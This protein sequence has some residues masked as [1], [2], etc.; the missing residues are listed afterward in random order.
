VSINKHLPHESAELHVSG[1]ADYTD[2]IPEVSGTLYCALGL[3]QRAHALITK[4]D[5]QHVLHAAGVVDVIT[6]TDIPGR[7]DCG[8]IQA[9]LL[10][11]IEYED[12][13]PVLTP[14]E[15]LQQ[16]SFVVPPIHRV[17]GNP[18][19]KLAEAPHRIDGELSIGGQE[20]F[21]LEG[22]ISYAIPKEQS[23]LCCCNRRSSIE[24]TDQTPIGS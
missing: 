14:K 7:N 5:L 24:S 18:D 15:A 17:Q 3:S 10:A 19:V 9:A 4:M 6:A 1:E 2:D 22:Q 8:P 13:A 16:Q 11:N 20:Q 23:G 12:L 21:Y